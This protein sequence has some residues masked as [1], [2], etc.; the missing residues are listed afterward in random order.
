M[1][2]ESVL[3]FFFSCLVCWPLVLGNYTVTQLWEKRWQGGLSLCCMS[4]ELEVWQIEFN[5][6][7]RM[8]QTQIFLLFAECSVCWLI[9][10]RPIA[11]ALAISNLFGFAGL[12]GSS[13]WSS[14]EV[15]FSNIPGEDISEHRWVSRVLSFRSFI[16]NKEWLVYLGIYSPGKQAGG[17]TA[18][19]LR[20]M[21]RP[22]FWERFSWAGIPWIISWFFFSF[23]LY[24]WN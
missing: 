1:D 5:H 19:S 11:V 23:F 8:V 6:F 18:W 2:L 12:K 22:H 15:I 3:I 4:P 20:G 9:L 7:M 10:R 24:W 17:I 13:Q 21:S 16:L 14:E